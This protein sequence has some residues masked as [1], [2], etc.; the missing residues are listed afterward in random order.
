MDAA[1]RRPHQNCE[2]GE[3]RDHNADK[4]D[5][6]EEPVVALDQLPAFRQALQWPDGAAVELEA[7]VRAWFHGSPPR[8]RNALDQHIFLAVA[9]LRRRGHLTE[10]LAVGADEPCARRPRAAG[11]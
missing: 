7:I 5:A 9:L 6:E 4:G 2:R 1:K 10:R 3:L 11:R 8:N